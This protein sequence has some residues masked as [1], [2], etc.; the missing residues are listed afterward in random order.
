MKKEELYNVFYKITIIAG[1]LFIS[2]II[3]AVI[4]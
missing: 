2:F 3:G 1:A 4:L